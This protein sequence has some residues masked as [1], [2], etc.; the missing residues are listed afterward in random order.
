M[1]IRV[2]FLIASCI[3]FI[4]IGL[5][6][7]VQPITGLA[8]N[9]DFYRLSTQIGTYF[10]NET[11]VETYD[12]NAQDFV[13]LR[14]R[15]GKPY[16]PQHYYSSEIIFLRIARLCHDLFVDADTF[17]IRMLGGVHF[18]FY[19]LAFLVMVLRLTHFPIISAWAGLLMLSLVFIDVGY[20]SYL[21]SFYSEPSSFI[22]FSLTLSVMLM[23]CRNQCRSFVFDTIA[24]V[25]FSVL[26]ITSKPQNA[27]SVP[28]LIIFWWLKYYPLKKHIIDHAG[29]AIMRFIQIA[30][31][32]ILTAV[33]AGYL[34]ELEHPFSLSKMNLYNNVFYYILPTMEN[35][36]DRDAIMINYL[37][38]D[39]NTEPLIGT[40]CRNV[41]QE[42]AHLVR[43]AFSQLN[44][45][46]VLSY[47]FHHPEAIKKALQDGAARSIEV[48]PDYLGNIQKGYGEKKSL[49]FKDLNFLSKI[50]LHVYPASLPGLAVLY[51]FIFILIVY[52]YCI[53]LNRNA[54]L[55]AGTLLLM[56]IAQFVG[57]IITGGMFEIVKHLYLYNYMIDLSLMLACVIL[58]NVLVSYRSH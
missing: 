19:C 54:S 5:R 41:P 53:G 49:L 1:K 20:Y 29:K 6:L 4:P 46:G 2:I 26:F 52:S 25:V 57:V 11:G 37:G 58:L 39:K 56:A 32:I 42:K 38:I 14:Y 45:K 35:I 16:N 27:S 34:K 24:F 55:V 51:L 13:A 17:D 15:L 43:L 28:F 22:F 31:A 50:K 21:N 8:N 36:A 30:I 9:G 3:I 48:M 18:F 40:H 12:P 10:I 44:Y 23:P 47:Y 33:S 7:F